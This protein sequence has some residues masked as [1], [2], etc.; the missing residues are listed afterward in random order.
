MPSWDGS[1]APSTI[2]DAGRALQGAITREW[3]WRS[4]TLTAAGTADAKTLTYSVA[5]AAYYNGQRFA[6]ISNTV[7]TTTATLNVN[8][9]GAKTIKYI[10]GAGT[11]TALVAGQM[12]AGQYIE[13]TFNTSADAWIW[14]NIGNLSGLLLLGTL[15]TS[16]GTT[17]SLTGIPSHV[18]SLMCEIDRVSGSASTALRVAVSANNGS[19]YGSVHT[20]SSVTGSDAG[21][22]IGTCWVYNIQTAGAHCVVAPVTSA[23]GGTPYVTADVASGNASASGPYNAIQFSI[24]GATF[25]NGSIKVWGLC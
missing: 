21:Q 20:I 6:F 11:A 4:Y 24:N 3:N 13:V 19:S 17:A 8:S 9:V 7:N 1:A 25:D 16:S 15:T 14:T 18:R 10:D 12:P 5:P 22:I 2:D 23:A